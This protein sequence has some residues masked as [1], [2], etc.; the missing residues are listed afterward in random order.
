MIHAS[1]E[2]ATEQTNKFL[3]NNHSVEKLNANMKLQ[4]QQ[5]QI[6]ST[7]A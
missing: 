5:Q 1:K 7:N 6:S 2:K 3:S 4:Y